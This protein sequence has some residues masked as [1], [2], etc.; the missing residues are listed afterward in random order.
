MKNKKLSVRNDALKE[1]ISYLRGMVK[2]L[3]NHI[4]T[5]A[6]LDEFCTVD[7]IVEDLKYFEKKNYDIKDAC[8]YG[9][10]DHINYEKR[11]W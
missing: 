3:I 8:I 4:G 2:Y 6:N 11:M 1:E 5:K 7:K 10:K 9:K